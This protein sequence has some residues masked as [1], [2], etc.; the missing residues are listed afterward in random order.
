MGSVKNKTLECKDNF[1]ATYEGL[2]FLLLFLFNLEGLMSTFCMKGQYHFFFFCTGTDSYSIYSGV[3][4][5][6][7]SL[8]HPITR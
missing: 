5:F 2:F 1:A 8:V 7:S 6:Q 4:Y 3:C